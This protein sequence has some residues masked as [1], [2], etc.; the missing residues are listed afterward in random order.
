MGIKDALQMDWARIRMVALKAADGRC[1]CCGRSRKD[2]V[3][4]NVDHIK[5][6]KTHP[7]I[8]LDPNNLQVLCGLCNKGKGNWDSTDWR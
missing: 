3:V 4:L 6:R 1:Q 2:G 5:P 7:E 8:A